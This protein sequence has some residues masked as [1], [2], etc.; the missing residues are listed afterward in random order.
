[1]YSTYVGTVLAGDMILA[2]TERRNS[3]S[4]I[5]DNILAGTLEQ[6]SRGQD[7]RILPGTANQ[8]FIFH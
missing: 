2:F 3:V 8:K 1:M 6:F 5:G 4:T 7:L